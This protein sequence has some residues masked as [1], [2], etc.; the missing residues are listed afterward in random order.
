MKAERLKT[1]EENYEEAAL[2]LALYRML[3]EERTAQN[4]DES[5][6]TL[7][8]SDESTPRILSLIDRQMR[9]RSGIS[10]ARILKTAAIALLILNMAL[11]IAAAAST[12]VRAKV[13]DFLT[14]INESY[15][16]VGFSQSESSVAVPE[17]WAERYYPT[18][19]PEGYTLKYSN[20]IEGFSEAEYAGAQGERL[21]IQICD[22]SAVS[23]INTENA[24]VSFETIS[25]ASATVLRQPYE[26][27][28]IVWAIGDRYFIV[29]A[30]DYETALSTAESIKPIEK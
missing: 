14:E 20:A 28:N 10:F 18:F 24:E 15:M 25:G 12:A 1:P 27:V 8:M 4:E 7:R 16:S 29:S 21:R 22:S 9:K 17:D 30:I 2:E 6:E 5:T 23:R 13:I 26:E 19:I 11:T 3:R